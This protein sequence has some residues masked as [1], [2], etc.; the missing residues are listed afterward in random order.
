MVGWMAVWQIFD[1]GDKQFRKISWGLLFLQ[2]GRLSSQFE[3][4]NQ[5]RRKVSHKSTL[6]S[7]ES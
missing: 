5:N 6:F 1:A 2:L 7:P 3:P 4:V